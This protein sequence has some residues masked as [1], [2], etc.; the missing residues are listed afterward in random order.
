[1]II[2]EQLR[3]RFHLFFEADNYRRII[4]Q[5]EVIIHCH[6]YNARL[7]NII[8][9]TR[10]INGK[11]IILSAT[12]EVF[13]EYIRNICSTE[14]SLE[15]QWKIAAC[16]YAHLGYGTLD[17]SLIEE[18]IVTSSSSHFVEGWKA[19]FK[20]VNRPVCTF[21]EGYLQ[22]VI[23]GITGK[24]V[25]VREEACM[26]AGAEQCRFKI[27][28]NRSKPLAF[29]AKCISN[30]IPKTQSNC[31]ES[32][33]INRHKIIKALVEMPLYGNNQGLIPKFNVYL[34]NTPADFYNLICIRFLEAMKEQNLLNT[35]QKLLVFAGE[36]CAVNT[37]RGIIIS[38]EWYELI[39]PMVKE[40]SDYLYGLIAITN[41][42]GWGNW[43]VLKYEPGEILEMESLNGYEAL[44]YLQ[45]RGEVHEPQCY[46]LTGI[47]AG[48]MELLHGEGTVE[49]RIG[50]YY[51]EE[52][53]CICCGE[54]S[55]KFSVEVL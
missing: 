46:M 1:M 2:E 24:S 23:H 28:T 22:G 8:E 35:G 4:A 45:Y 53:N 51:A 6:H 25:Y 16:L 44:G 36:V 17:F 54:E 21:T 34:A 43:H 52:S 55:C 20:E 18:G 26:K 15:T 14:D 7:Q 41:A 33:N 13:S 47:A 39:L 11:E 30:F 12:E 50:T 31:L 5:K 42:L 29:S 37:L 9:G 27:D 32:N 38:Q 10:Q 3:E 19:G 48:I 40:E 49:E